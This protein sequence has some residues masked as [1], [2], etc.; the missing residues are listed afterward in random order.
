MK[1]AGVIVM[2]V[3]LTAL[4][5]CALLLPLARHADRRGR[6]GL[7][8]SALS[9]LRR[10][11]LPSLLALFTAFIGSVAHSGKTN[12]GTGTTGILPVATVANGYAIPTGGTPVVPVTVTPEEIVQGYRL[13]SV[14]TNDAVSYA[15]P[16]NGAEYA[17]WN[18]R[19]GYET[20]FPLDLGDF[21]FPFGTSV[22]RRLDVLS[23]GT[24]ESLPRQ[25]VN[26]AYYSPMSICAAREWASIVPGV[27]RFWWADAA[28]VAGRPPYRTKLLTWENVYAGRDRTGQY[29]AQ[30]ELRGDGNFITRSN[31]VERTYRRINPD[32]WDGD[33]I[34]NDVDG[35]PCFYDGD[36]N[37]PSNL[38]PE[39]ANT[40]AYCTV[41][42]VV[43][44]PDALVSFT[45]DGPSDYPDPLFIAK[46]GVTNEVVILIGK[47]YHVTSS[48]PLAFVGVSD[49]ETDIVQL[50][51]LVIR[52]VRP[53]SITS[54]GGN[55]FT[56]S[57][58]PDN[59]AGTFSWGTN[60]CNSAIGSGNIFGFLCSPDCSCGGC[61]AE[62]SYLYEGYRLY[63]LGGW[64]GCS[65]QVV[66]VDD[67]VA[68]LDW[69]SV[70]DVARTGEAALPV[71]V[72]LTSPVPTN[73]VLSLIWGSAD[74][75]RVCRD[76]AL[77]ETI[78]QIEEIGV[79]NCM[80]LTTNF[81]LKGVAPSPS[82][83]NGIVGLMWK[84]EFGNRT[85]ISKP[86]TVVERRAEPITDE[87]TSEVSPFAVFNPSCANAGD[88][89]RLRVS[90]LPSQMPGSDIVWRCKS[91][92]ASFVG[93]NTGMSV[94]AR[95]GT[96]TTVFAVQVGDCRASELELT[97][98][99][100][101]S[102]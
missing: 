31:N 57:V 84:D 82:Y 14:T 62:G 21:A 39:N 20:H 30:I 83:E 76:S 29:N 52:V 32:D 75:V 86:F 33:G 73:G 53:V 87:R 93:G 71:S 49:P 77:T 35:N 6:P 15:M 19:G 41:S 99:V 2:W 22:V 78:R 1:M 66:Q 97:V 89:V 38:L 65:A 23:G 5:L 11:T 8:H 46:S 24:V 34:P 3:M 13:E 67:V 47:T 94:K 28:A 12:G 42:V 69:P 95:M 64:C 50:R 72:S 17:P 10:L 92:S 61:T 91:G 68:S 26:G 44:G 81:Y 60:C 96:D 88:E 55:P 7:L 40:N 51:G 98:R 25:R 9:N 43:T 101:P 36:F 54:D 100:W 27:G 80:S 74:E 85:L 37:G 70:I 45:G 18:L 16:T 48:S 79:T 59:L 58:S 56:M 63:A 90:V 4:A 102:N